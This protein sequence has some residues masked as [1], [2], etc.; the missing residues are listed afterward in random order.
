MGNRESSYRVVKC[1]VSKV[2][3]NQVDRVPDLPSRQVLLSGSQLPLD[4]RRVLPSCRMQSQ[5]S[6][7]EKLIIRL[8]NIFQAQVDHYIESRQRFQVK[9]EN[10]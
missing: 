7:V 6:R 10:V 5:E 4:Q 9:K 2:P 1:E 8:S 3:V